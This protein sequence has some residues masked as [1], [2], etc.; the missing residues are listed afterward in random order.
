MSQINWRRL[1]TD[2]D[3]D[4]ALS[5]SNEGTVALFKHSTRCSV[6]SMALKFFEQS[7]NYDD[8]QVTPYFLD[9]IAYR[10]L[11]NRIASEL[12]VEHQSPQLILVRNGK[13]IL[14]RSHNEINASEIRSHLG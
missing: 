13:A 4:A 9:L 11:S 12:N 2:Q 6:S 10:S 14:N 7:W 3:L 8:D 1:Q 5:A